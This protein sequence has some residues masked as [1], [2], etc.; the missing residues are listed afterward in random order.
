MLNTQRLQILVELKRRGTLTEV[1]A[2]LNY[3]PSAVS[4]H[5]AALSVEV[6]APLIE[7][8]GR[9]VRLTPQAEILV[10][11]AG[12]L[13]EQMEQAEAEL[14]ESLGGLRGRL[15]LATFQ[16]A[17]L[18]LVPQLLDSLSDH[19]DV[20]LEIVHVQPDSG[21][22]ALAA[23]ECDLLIGE[24]YPGLPFAR[25]ADVE[26][27]DLF[28]D[29]MRVLVPRDWPTHGRRA[30]ASFRDAP[31]V[32][33]PLGNAARTWMSALCREA[34]FEPRVWYESPDLLVHIRLVETGH[35]VAVVPDLVWSTLRAPGVL[36]ALP[37]RSTRRVFTAVR[38]GATQ[39]PLVS[40]VRERLGRVVETVTIAIGSATGQPVEPLSEPIDLL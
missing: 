1:A 36:H 34:G 3:S 21:F 6:R 12:R 39:H 7:P 31:W 8:A 13:L 40:L 22:S 10:A 35:A 37:G 23:H 4:Q 30:L 27:A 9:R 25:S 28:T 5:L 11:H 14:A 15:R 32:M 26:V 18:G 20:Q 2:A 29:P 17:F 16:T 24:E 19:P 38:A 33:E